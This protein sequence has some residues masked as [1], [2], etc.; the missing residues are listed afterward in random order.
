LRIQQF[1]IVRPQGREALRLL[2]RLPDVEHQPAS[3]R[4]QADTHHHAKAYQ[5][6]R[7]RP[8]GRHTGYKNSGHVK[9]PKTKTAARVR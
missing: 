8:I 3:R 7:P 1:R 6:H 4:Q 2:G 5:Q 9:P